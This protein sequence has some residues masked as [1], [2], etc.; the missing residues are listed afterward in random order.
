[1]LFHL[2]ESPPLSP[3]NFLIPPDIIERDICGRSVMSGKGFL[4]KKNPSRIAPHLRSVTSVV[5][6]RPS[7][8]QPSSVQ[9]V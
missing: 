5:F 1:M 9:H 7:T 6:L 2:K 4:K 8:N 3:P